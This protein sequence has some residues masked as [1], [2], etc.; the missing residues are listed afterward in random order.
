MIMPRQAQ[1]ERFKEL[2]ELDLAYSVPGLGRFRC[3]VYH[4]RGTVALVFRIIRPSSRRSMR[5]G[6]RGCSR[7]SPTRTRGLVR[8]GTTGSGKSTSLAR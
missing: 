6:C 3:N 7:A 5:S 8:H 1:F 4:Q 2:S